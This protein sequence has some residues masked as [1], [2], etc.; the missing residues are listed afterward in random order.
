MEH[1]WG[2]R[3]ST[4]V[5]VR[6]VSRTKIGTG[7]L[8]NVSVTGAFMKTRD[9][10]RLLSVLHLSVASHSGKTNSKGAAAFVVRRE[11]EGVGLEWCEAGHTSVEARLA[12]LAGDSIDSTA[13]CPVSGSESSSPAGR[14]RRTAG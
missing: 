1:R 10:L 9:R 13:D 6:F 3:Q 11:S 7:C 2:R 12:L 8:L 14:V 4:D 5:P